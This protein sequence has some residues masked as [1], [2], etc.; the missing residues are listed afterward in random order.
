MFARNAQTGVRLT[1]YDKIQKTVKHTLI[2]SLGSI[3]NSTF[4]V[5]LV[6]LYTRKLKTSEYGVL[7]LLTITLTLV[8]IVL[9]FGLNHAFFRHYYDTED[10]AHRRR[11][12]GSTLIFL[13]ISATLFTALLYGLAPQLSVLIFKDGQ[14]AARHVGV[15]PEATMRAE[16]QQLGRP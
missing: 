4:G 12:V 1:I 2:F 13:L 6:P 5:L 8:S 10:P 3:V 9:K 16:M 11:I 15:T 7:S 14:I